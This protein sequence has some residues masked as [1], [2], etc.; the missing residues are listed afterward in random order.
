MPR[1]QQQ[2]YIAQLAQEHRTNAKLEGKRYSY[3]AKLDMA[4]DLSDKPAIWFPYSADFRGRLYPSLGDLTPQG[5]DVAKAML[6]FAR[7]RA[8]GENGLFWL[9]VR[10][11]NCFGSEGDLPLDKLPFKQRV[12]W[13]A[14]NVAEICRVATDPIQGSRWWT[15][16]DEPWSFLA[17]CVELAE[18]FDNPQSFV[19]HL[20]IPMDGSCNGLQHLA[21]MGRDVTGARAT[22]VLPSEDRRDIY[23]EVADIISARVVEDAGRG[24]PIAALWLGMVNRKVVK[25]AVMTT[26]YGVTSRGIREQ[27]MEDGREGRKEFMAHIPNHLRP[28]AADYLRDCL[29]PAIEQ[30]VPA[31]KQI[32]SWLQN[33]S[34][35][36]AQ[37]GIPFVWE[38]PT[39]NIIKQSYFDLTAREIETLAG[40]LRLYKETPEAGLRKRKQKL[41]AA[42]NVIHSFDAAHLCRTVNACH[43][44]GIRDFAMIHDS[45]ATH[46]ADADVMSHVLRREFA[47]IYRENWLQR[48]EDYVRS[49][50]ETP[51]PSWSDYL[52]LGDLDVSQVMKADFFFA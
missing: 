26:P 17:T 9:C 2:E 11:A 35:T 24:N 48:I 52:S 6:M 13:V 33:V 47:D 8:L 5:D 21:A 16:A 32:M 15:K 44:L 50:T 14:G 20:P 22:N 42:P 7:G 28:E 19:S 41:A 3:L 31:A 51:I 37:S 39:G 25:R 49:Y 29:E 38:T 23:T 45:F 12:D 10:A 43:A 46:A 40:R 36:L 1:K 34:H 4:T 18:A 27:L 30:Q